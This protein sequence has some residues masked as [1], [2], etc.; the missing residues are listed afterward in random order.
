[1]ATDFGTDLSCLT[2]LTST[3]S[4]TSGRRLVGEAIA[5]RLQTPRGRLLKHP[6]YGFDL[7]GAINDDLAQADIAAIGS[8]VEAECLK[9][10]RVIAASVVS[11][12][13]GG[14]LTV[15]ITLTDADGPFVLVFAASSA[16]VTLVSGPGT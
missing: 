10:E 6:N 3:M 11:T 14:V 9:D 16:S 5:R 2:D 4:T 7:A 15:A 8:S 1:M 13:V 12:F